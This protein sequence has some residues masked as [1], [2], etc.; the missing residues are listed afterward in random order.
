MG[1]SPIVRPGAEA[2]RKE[3]IMPVYEYDCKQCKRTFTEKQTFQEHDQHRKVKCPKCGS[4]A[5]QQLIS[6]TFA[7][8]SKKS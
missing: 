3:E 5:V 8:T 7:K 4:A 6:P 2:G 1:G